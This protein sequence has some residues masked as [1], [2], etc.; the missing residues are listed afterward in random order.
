M[1]YPEQLLVLSS[2]ITQAEATAVQSAEDASTL[3]GSNESII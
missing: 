2:V 3:V 1:K